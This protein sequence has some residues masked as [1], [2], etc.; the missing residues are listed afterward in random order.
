MCLVPSRHL[1]AGCVDVAYLGGAESDRVE[2]IRSLQFLANEEQLMVRQ[3]VVCFLYPSCPFS[4][5]RCVLL[6]SACCCLFNR[7]VIATGF[8]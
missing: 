2:F 5:S 1:A 6:A 8:V 3:G 4:A 7:D